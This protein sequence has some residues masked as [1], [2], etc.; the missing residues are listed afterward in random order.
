MSVTR[1]QIDV[2]SL[3]FGLLKYKIKLYKNIEKSTYNHTIFPYFR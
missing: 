3:L 2:Y 1:E